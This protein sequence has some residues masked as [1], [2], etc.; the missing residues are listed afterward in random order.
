MQ[1]TDLCSARDII[2]TVRNIWKNVVDYRRENVKGQ[3]ILHWKT[4]GEL[5]STSFNRL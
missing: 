5:V 3:I 4:N 2:P 1:G